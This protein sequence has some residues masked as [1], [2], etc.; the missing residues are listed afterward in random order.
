MNRQAFTLVELSIVLVILGLL[1]GGVL[2]GQSLIRAA[3]LR[4][5]LTERD[6]YQTAINAF[7]DK[8]FA[9]PGDM[10][11][12]Y[13][14]W[15]TAGVA[16]CA[17]DTNAADTGCNGNGNGQYTDRD[18][19]IK[20][21]MHLGLAGLIEGT[22]DGV[23]IGADTM[24]AGNVPKSKFA[25]GAWA[26]SSISTDPANI[27]YPPSGT[28]PN[29]GIY[30]ILGSW[31]SMATTGG[32]LSSLTHE[33]AWNLDTKSDDGRGNTG[34]MRGNNGADCSDLDTDGNAANGAEDAYG[35]V[36]DGPG[37][38]GDCTLAFILRN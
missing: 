18:E 38:T 27:A 28:A 31:G 30:L 17:A 32:L 29:G 19:G 34:K 5:I 25:D 36:N 22:Y 6:R 20:A 1:V 7:R 12:A 10:K 4:S 2:S 14:F 23:G 9:L 11:N 16:G 8:Y 26:L 15:G 35:I 21:W 37:F 13:A 33:E 3:E 24:G